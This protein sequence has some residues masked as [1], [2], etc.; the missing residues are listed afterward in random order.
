MSYRVG[1]DTKFDIN[2][3][4]YNYVN[5]I[6]SY[7][8]DFFNTKELSNQKKHIKY[9][10]KTLIQQSEKMLR[11]YVDTLKIYKVFAEEKVKESITK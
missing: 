7:I 9:I 2:I 6:S 4:M 8:F 10:N 1:Y 11:V 5:Y 3:I